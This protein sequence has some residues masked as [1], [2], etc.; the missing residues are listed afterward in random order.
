MFERFGLGIF[1]I[2]KWAELGEET[3][4]LAIAYETIREAEEAEQIE[5]LMQASSLGALKRRV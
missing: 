2:G 5:G 1:D 4:V 3:Q